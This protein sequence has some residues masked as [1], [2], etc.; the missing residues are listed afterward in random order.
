M[1]LLEVMVSL[2]ISLVAMAL[3]SS[4]LVTT[5]RIG[6]DKR[7]TAMAALAARN[8]LETMRS[9]PHSERYA[10]YN[11][12]PEDDPAGKG[13]APGRFFAVDGLTPVPGDKDGFVGEIE[14]PIFEGLLRED[15]VDEEL[16]LPRDL[17]GD[18]LV[19]KLDHA[20]DY[21]ILPV[22][23]VIEW[24]GVSGPRRIVMCSMLTDLTGS[25][26]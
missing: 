23:V 6:A 19:D 26:P 22:R 15:A 8:V 16:G 13:T 20:D 9:A 24:Q 17:D 1:T 18:T 12:N 4:A 11:R 25:V 21:V 2:S 14:I 10:L 5:S 7:L 3:F